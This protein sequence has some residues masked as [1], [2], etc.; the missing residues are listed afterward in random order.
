MLEAVISLGHE[1]S[2]DLSAPLEARMP[3]RG[4]LITIGQ[5][6]VIISVRRARALS[7]ASVRAI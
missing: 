1:D 2:P 5:R 4:F 7:S 3:K 6:A